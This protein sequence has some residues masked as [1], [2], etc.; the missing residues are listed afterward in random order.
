MANTIG[1]FDYEL[2][3]PETDAQIPFSAI[4]HIVPKTFSRDKDGWPRL[5]PQLMTEHEIDAHIQA[6]KEDLDHVGRLAKR[7][8]QRANSRTRERLSDS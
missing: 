4:I 8:L 3:A 7:E 1:R 2:I 6:L 5:S